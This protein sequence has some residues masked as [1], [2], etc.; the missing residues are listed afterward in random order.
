MLLL[1]LLGFSSG[2][3]LALTA[4][5][6]KALRVAQKKRA[7]VMHGH[8]VIPGGVIAAAARPSLPLVVSLHGSDVFVAERT[9]IAR[10]AAAAPVAGS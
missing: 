10:T 7:T 6:F 4:G 9:A 3:P 8:W 1:L 5:W 2:L